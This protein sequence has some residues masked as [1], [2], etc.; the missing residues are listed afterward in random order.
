M[1]DNTDNTEKEKRFAETLQQV[2][3]LGKKQGYV[4]SKEQVSEAFGDLLS[5]DEQLDMVLE[6]LKL[7]KIGIGE[8]ADL[9]AYLSDEETDYLSVYLESLGEMEPLSPGE[10]EALTLAAM[11]GEQAAQQRILENFLPHVAE[12]SKLYA[13][14]GVY[15]EDLIGEGNLALARGVTMLGAMEHAAEAQGMLAKMVMDA[16]EEYINDN[17][18]EAKKYE[19]AVKRVNAV[20]DQ[21]NELAEELRRKVSV[22]ELMQETGMSRDKILEAVRISGRNIESLDL[23]EDA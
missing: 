2:Q 20:A 19:K 14:Q 3:K 12:I 16:M 13:G 11:A 5:G 23:S 1:A 7:H 8:P 4:I 6:Y 18:E 17:A 22:E 15:L 9:D 10:E 21:A